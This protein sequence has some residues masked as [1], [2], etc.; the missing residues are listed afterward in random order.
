[1]ESISIILS[2]FQELYSVQSLWVKWNSLFQVKVKINIFEIVDPFQNHWILTVCKFIDQITYWIL[3]ENLN[4][5]S[6]KAH[7]SKIDCFFKSST[8]LTEIPTQV[9]CQCLQNDSSSSKL[10]QNH[11]T[12]DLRSSDEK[13]GKF[14]DN[15]QTDR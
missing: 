10:L 1:M 13:F 2:N 4:G 8:R 9:I 5:D 6:P 14:N 15:T 11:S 12:E 3:E 7:L